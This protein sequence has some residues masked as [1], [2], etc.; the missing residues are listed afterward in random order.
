MK[1]AHTRTGEGGLFS[2]S[3]RFSDAARPHFHP[4]NFI[5][6][7]N[8]CLHSEMLFTLLSFI[9]LASQQK[10]KYLKTPRDGEKQ[11][12]KKIIVKVVNVQVEFL[13][14]THQKR[15][16]LIPL[17]ASDL[18]ANADSPPPEP[19]ERVLRNNLN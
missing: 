7:K 19:V 17:L 11:E 16:R 6:Q 8:F 3:P 4:F 15:R 5:S 13:I 18:V 12:R 2:N 1:H 9:C 10:Q 14:S